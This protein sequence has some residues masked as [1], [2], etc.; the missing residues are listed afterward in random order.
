MRF[1]AL[2]AGVA[3]CLTCEA[4]L[5]FTEPV[6][7]PD[8]GFSMPNLAGAV[9]APIDLPR[10]SAYLVSGLGGRR[11]EDRYDTFGLWTSEAVRGRWRDPE[12]RMLLI[13]RLAT[14][15]PDD[16]PGTV[17][18]RRSY[19]DS[20]AGAAID[21]KNA[22][23]R[24]EAAEAISPVELGR[25]TPPRRS[26]RKN[27][28]GI[29]AYPSGEDNVLVYAFRPRSPERRENPCWFLAMLAAV[30]GED[31][32]A[33][34]A[35]FDED[36][37]DRISV[38]SLGARRSLAKPS[39]G[40]Q[41]DASEA[42]LLRA[43]LRSSVANYDDWNC[44]EAEDV[45]V[46]DDLDPGVRAPLLAS[47]TNN[48]PRLRRVYARVAPSSLSATNVLAAVRVF[49]DKE[50]YLT[51][52]GTN[53]VW[54]SALWSPERREL[55]LYH[56]EGGNETLLRTVWH[57]AFHQ[58]LAYAG[59]MIDSSPW[60]NEGIAQLFEFSRFD[61][62]GNA[63]FDRDPQ[64]AAY[65]HEYAS[66]IAEKLPEIFEMDYPEFY[67]GSQAQILERYRIAWSIAYFLEVGA[68]RLRFR[69]YET[70]RADYMKALVE[71]RSMTEATAKAFGDEKSRD[72]FIAAWLAFWRQ[73]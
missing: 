30:P 31:M 48:L 46:L 62:R 22:Q 32:A 60:F 7:R 16:L 35:R 5:R 65:V 45:I 50:E 59:A 41:P 58:Y 6:W 21:P 10:A 9:A 49:R 4:A 53:Q 72:E 44:A 24:D 8:L 61:R 37:L 23:Q 73:N 12:G 40:P 28:A 34:R 29:V 2:T 64:A 20:R 51:Y 67:S 52:V 14:Q 11:L 15:P 71:T 56:P 57:E 33:V 55:V 66:S 63:V 39:P 36:F 13:A 1:S 42:D 25:A 54:T 17:C 3:I 19:R 38:P 18:T 69:P 70:L 26:Q 27:M 43:D 68:P 47:L